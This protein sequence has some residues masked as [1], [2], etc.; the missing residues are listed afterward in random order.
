MNFGTEWVG[1]RIRGFSIGATESELW[2]LSFYNGPGAS[3]TVADGLM[4]KH[5][6]KKCKKTFGTKWVGN[7]FHE[8]PIGATES[9]IWDLSFYNG[10][11]ASETVVDGRLSKTIKCEG[12]E[13]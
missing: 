3:E 2:N 10:P 4:T 7:R 1:N 13:N 11:G 5:S 6:D 8:L 12:N 9:E